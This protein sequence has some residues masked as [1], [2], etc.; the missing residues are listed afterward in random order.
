MGC[1]AV[2]MLLFDSFVLL[3]LSA[4]F[5]CLFLKGLSLHTLLF[6]RFSVFVGFGDFNLAVLAVCVSKHLGAAVAQWSALRS[7]HPEAVGS[8]LSCV[9][10]NTRCETKVK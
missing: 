1:S 7:P 5:I 8:S 6:S 2:K 4:S 9:I 3:S 10:K